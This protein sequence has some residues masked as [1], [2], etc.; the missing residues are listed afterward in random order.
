MGLVGRWLV[1]TK[2]LSTPET[3]ADWGELARGTGF[4]QT[5][6]LLSVLVFIPY[7]GGA[8]AAVIF[9]WRFIAML[10]AVQASLDYDS[11]WRAFF[12]VLIAFI[13]V[14]ILAAIVFAILA[15]LGIEET[16]QSAWVLPGIFNIIGV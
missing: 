6:G 1:G 4:A 8:I 10:M 14:L 15:T 3:R 5:P 12:V 7:A 2:I 16:E 11:M 13:P 9:V